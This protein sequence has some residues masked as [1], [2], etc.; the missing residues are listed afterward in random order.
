MDM[1]DDRPG[2]AAPP[3]WRHLAPPALGIVAL[4]LFLA[5]A[6]P[7]S[8]AYG[9]RTVFEIGHVPL[10]G[11][12]GLL[13]LRLV[14]LLRGSPAPAAV[15]LLIALLATTVLSL[16][17]EALQVFLPGRDANVGD[18]AKNLVGVVTFLALVAAL[19]P[20]LWQGLGKDGAVA[21]RLVLAGAVLTLLLALAPVAG[22]AWHYA[23]RAAALPVV[24]DF[25]RS[26]QRPFLSLGRSELEQARAPDGWHEMK[27]RPVSR[28][29]FLDAPWPGITVREP[30]PDWSGYR[31]LEFQVWSELEQPVELVLRVD[32]THRARAHADR[33]NG[34]FIVVPGLNDFSVPLETIASGPRDRELDLRH[35]SQFILFSRRPGEPFS[36]YLG[37]FRLVGEAER[38]AGAGAAD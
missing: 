21:A 10:F 30:Y 36:L 24:A 26:W 15:D 38:I 35:V 4:V 32:D 13:M 23:Q 2:P 3:D 29:T 33:F 11:C 17:T 8:D 16:A 27:G 34:S 37:P 22:I 19:R 18:A 31:A 25:T 1:R 9:W 7:P 14:Q 6:R 28:L 5:L 20:A 12:A